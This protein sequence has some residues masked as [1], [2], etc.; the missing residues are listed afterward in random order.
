MRSEVGRTSAEGHRE[1]MALLHEARY[2]LRLRTGGPLS[3]AV[4]AGSTF[5]YFD[6]LRKIIAEARA[7]LLFVDPYMGV[8]F[9]AKYLVQVAA[10]T[11]IRLLTRERLDILIPA[12]MALMEQSG[13]TIAVRSTDRIHDRYVFID[14]RACFL[15]GASFKDGGRNAPTIVTQITDAFAPMLDTYERMW[16]EANVHI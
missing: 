7:D 3:V 14:H 2:D 10:G 4:D 1:V 15:S 8:D 11:S 9:I 6:T 12:V 5:D 16:A 13:Q